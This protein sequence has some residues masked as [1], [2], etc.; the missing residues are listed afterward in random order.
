MKDFFD[1]WTLSKQYS[2]HSK[3]LASAIQATFDQR[4]T[5]KKSSPDCFSK[6]F[7]ANSLKKS[8]WASFIHKNKLNIDTD[9]FSS[10]VE[11][12]R[13]FLDPVLE[14]IDSSVVPDFEWNH[15][16]SWKTD[17]HKKTKEPT[18]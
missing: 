6:A 5:S 7:A 9:S 18:N 10:V 16:K 2:F 3:T 4:G 17:D 1:I 13:Q 12:L 15:S 8:Q 11:D 14:W